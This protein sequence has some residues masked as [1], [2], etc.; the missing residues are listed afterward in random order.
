MEYLSLPSILPLQNKCLQK[1]V[2]E[3]GIIYK[4]NNQKNASPLPSLFQCAFGFSLFTAVH[5]QSDD[6]DLVSAFF[7]MRYIIWTP[8]G[9]RFYRE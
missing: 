2:T 6:P 4:R 1:T 9:C 3:E 8:V 7:L 5:F